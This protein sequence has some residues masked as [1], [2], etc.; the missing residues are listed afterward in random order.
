M[1]VAQYRAAESMHDLIER[2][3]TCLYAS[4]R[5]GRNRV[6]TDLDAGNLSAA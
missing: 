6:T 4:K 2:A 3:D 1:G 5:A